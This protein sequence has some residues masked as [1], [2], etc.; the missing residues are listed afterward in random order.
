MVMPSISN[1][2]PLLCR[3]KYVFGHFCLFIC[4]PTQMTMG[5]NRQSR[6]ELGLH[7]GY[8]ALKVQGNYIHM[9]RAGV[10]YLP[11][12]PDFTPPPP[13][14]PSSPVNLLSSIPLSLHLS[15][16]CTYDFLNTLSLQQPSFNLPLRFLSFPLSLSLSFPLSL[17]FSVSPSVVAGA[18][19]YDGG[20]VLIRG[21]G[22]N[23][24]RARAVSAHPQ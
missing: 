3:V 6:A 20:E 15:I 13:S 23:M 11:T 4:S 9:H 1:I 12:L 2:L 24:K 8:D 19:Q 18:A 16:I 14:S 22:C 10:Y 21:R 17:F 7:M 5:F